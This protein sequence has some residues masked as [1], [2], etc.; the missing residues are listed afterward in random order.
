MSLAVYFIDCPANIHVIHRCWMTRFY[1][2][3]FLPFSIQFQSWIFKKVKILTRKDKKTTIIK[4]HTSEKTP[5]TLDFVKQSSSVTLYNYCNTPSPHN[6]M[7]VLLSIQKYRLNIKRQAPC[8]SLQEELYSKRD[9]DLWYF[10]FPRGLQCITNNN[11][12]RW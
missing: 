7:T 3:F 12:N 11:P 4:E 10:I 8:Q 6:T 5:K 1:R 9:N 2:G